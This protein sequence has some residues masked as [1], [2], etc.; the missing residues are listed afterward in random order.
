MQRQLV[1]RGFSSARGIADADVVVLNSCTV[2][3][4]A[5]LGLRQ[6]ARKTR[7]LNPA[8]RVVVT[9]C[10][11]QRNPEDLASLA[12]IDWVV[13]NSHKNEIAR[14]LSEECSPRSANTQFVPLGSLSAAAPAR[15]GDSSST[16]EVFALASGS[17]AKILR[18][19]I[20]VHHELLAAPVFD[21]SAASGASVERT[22]PNLKVQDGCNNRCS[23]CVIPYVRGRSRSLPLESIL[24]QVRALASAGYQEVVLSG[25][26]LGR[27]G[28]DFSGRRLRFPQLVRSI[29]D[30]TAIARLRLSSVEPM[31]F[32]DE[33]LDLMAASPRIA[34]HVHAPL[35]SGSDRILRRMHRKYHPHNYR[36]RIEAAYARMPNAA[37][38]ADVMVG[39]PG[40]TDADFE[41]TRSL[42]DSLPFTYLHVFPFSRRPGTPADTM[43]Q[44]VPGDVVRERARILRELAAQNN[45]RFRERQVGG[46][47]EV[48]TLESAAAEFAGGT[49]AISDNFLDVLLPGI[50]IPANRLIRVRVNRLTSE[51]LA[52]AISSA[53]C[54]AEAQLICS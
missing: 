14:L 50:Q 42:I 43:P 10:Y 7:R 38:G 44:Q 16:A 26:N 45:R 28:R 8:A 1:A 31:D 29:I 5:D 9:G 32:T 23:F 2:T 39:F 48:V 19:D 21:S 53:P 12:E 27:W 4:S 17:S 40:E 52:G 15:D 18:G 25:I 30:E 22:R 35:Q 34:K 24:E 36:N 41:E 11:A 33:L 37:Y 47:L 51:G 54:A 46:E 49:L 20:F 6:A 13:G 3:A